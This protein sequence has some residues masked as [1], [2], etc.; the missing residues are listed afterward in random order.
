V[1]TEVKA[2]TPKARKEY[3]CGWCGQKIEVG[4]KHFSRAYVWNGDFNTDRMHLECKDAMDRSDTGMLS[5]GWS[6]GS[7]ARGE[8]AQ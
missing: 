3:R 4:L 5:E 8:R 1:Y 6:P 2:K 7:F